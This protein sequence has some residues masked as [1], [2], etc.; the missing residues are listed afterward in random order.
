[1]HVSCTHTNPTHSYNSHTHTN[2]SDAYLCDRTGASQTNGSG[3]HNLQL[4]TAAV[5]LRV[6]L[7]EDMCLRVCRLNMQSLAN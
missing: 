3:S 1:M 6:C 5:S 4:K 2:L 7:G